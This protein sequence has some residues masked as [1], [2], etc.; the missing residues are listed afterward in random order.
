MVGKAKKRTTAQEKLLNVL[1]D[2][3]AVHARSGT[4]DRGGTVPVQTSIADSITFAQ[5][6]EPL[7]IHFGN[8]DTGKLLTLPTDAQHEQTFSK[9]LAASA[10]FACAGKEIVDENYHKSGK[11]VVD[12]FLTSLC[13]YQA[14]V[15]TEI[16]SSEIADERTG[17]HHCCSRTAFPCTDEAAKAFAKHQLCKLNICGAWKSKFK[18]HVD[19]PHSESRLG[20]IVVLLLVEHEGGQLILRHVGNEVLFDWSASSGKA[21]PVPCVEW[22]AF[23]SD[24]EHEVLEVTGSHRVTLA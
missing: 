8:L 1:Q 4:F 23:Y 21:K 9:F 19:T 16:I 14:S 10:P 24:C 3:I 12:A 11:L 22:A 18:P 5:V 15:F 13:P 6:S 2:A 17:W 20:S 7:Q